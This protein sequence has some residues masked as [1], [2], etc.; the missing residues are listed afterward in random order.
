MQAPLLTS[1]PPLQ[2]E[3]WSDAGGK[4]KARQGGETGR[5]GP[6][7]QQAE[8]ED[9]SSGAS[10]PSKSPLLPRAAR[11]QAPDGDAPR[12]RSPP[13]RP[14]GKL[15]AAGGGM[16]I[17]TAQHGGAGLSGIS[18]GGGLRQPSSPP[19]SKAQYNQWVG[20]QDGGG[21]QPASG[22]GFGGG[23]GAAAGHRRLFD[24][25]APSDPM[26]NFQQPSGLDD[27]VPNM[28]D[29]TQ[30]ADAPP[31]FQQQQWAIPAMRAHG[32]PGLQLGHGG[33]PSRYSPAPSQSGRR[34]AAGDKPGAAI[35]LG[36]RQA[37]LKFLAYEVRQRGPGWGR[38]AG[39]QQQ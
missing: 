35:K 7:H 23:G 36:R 16:R 24:M 34:A 9:A 22:G 28:G 6:S 33:Q 26:T 27:G 39:R 20:S 14:F 25:A 19:M 12:L 15:N 10:S 2:A 4:G 37:W 30:E 31:P 11:F 3:S 21:Q 17:N 5:A 32:S 29:V 13:A 1:I 8:L 38:L 18:G